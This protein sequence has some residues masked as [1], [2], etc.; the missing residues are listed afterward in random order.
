MHCDSDQVRRLLKTSN[1]KSLFVEQLGWDDH[2]ATIEAV[3]N[4]QA[5]K[6]AA[7]AQKRGVV[8]FVHE[9]AIPDDQTRRR[10]DRTVTKS[11][12]QHFIIFSDHGRAE[13]VWQWVRREP[14]KPLV[15]RQHRFHSSQSGESLIQKLKAITFSLKEEEDL[16]HVDV[17]GRVRAA[18]DT[19]RIT[20]RFYDR[21]KSEHEK[22]LDFIKGIP[23]DGLQHWYAAVMLNRLMFIY[24]VQKKEF[25]DNDINYLRTKLGQSKQ[26]G[27]DRFYTGFLC[28]LFFDGFAKKESER[29]TVT[30]ELLGKVPY[31]NGGLFLRHQVEELQGTSI[32][33]GDAAFER[34]FAFFEEFHWHLDERP[35]RNDREINPDVLGY[36]F[37]KYINQKQMGAYYTKE[38]ITGYIS[39]NTIIPFLFDAAR[40]KCKVAFEGDQS[41]WRLLQV[42]PDRYIYDAVKHGITIDLGEKPPCRIPEPPALPPEIACGLNDVSK[43]TEWN[44]SAAKDYAL[45][46][47]I[48]REVIARRKRY[49]DVRF[50]LASGDIQSINDLITYNLDIRQFAQDVIEQC[51][52]PDLLRAFWHAIQEVT[53]LDPTCGSGAFLFA[54]L[55]ILEPLYEACLNR[56]EV[57]LDELDRS[58]KKHR[59]EKFDDFR[60]AL[61]RVAKHASPRSFIYKSIIVNNLYGVDIMEEAVEICKLRLFLK[62]V[63][64]VDRVEQIEPL[65]D[66][67]FNIR[68]GNTLVGYATYDAVKQ[69]VQSKLDFENVMARIEEQAQDVDQLFGLFRRQQTELGGMV[70]AADKQNLRKRLKVLEEEL[71]RYLALEYQVN[72]SNKTAYLK[73]HD[74]H[75]PFHWLIEFYRTMKAGGFNVIIGNPP[76]VEY[77][78]KLQRQYRVSNYLTLACG[79][80]HAFVA[81]RSLTLVSRHGHVGLIVPLPSINTERMAA[82]QTIVKPRPHTAGRSTWISAYDERPSNLFTGVDQRLIIEIIGAQ[83][84][85][86]KLFTTGINRW[87]SKTRHLLF[88]TLSYAVQEEEVVQRTRTILKIKNTSIETHLLKALYSNDPIDRFRVSRSTKQLLAYRTAGG[89]YWKVTLDHPFDSKTLSG[90]VAYLEGISGKQAV[91]LISSS[92]FWWYYSCHFDMYNLKDYMI[93]GFRFSGFSKAEVEELDRLG[94]KLIKSLEENAVTQR[95]ES[96]TRGTVMQKL[97]VASKSKE[98]IDEIDRMLT[99]HYGFTDE[100]LD[101]I[102]NY[103][104]KYRMGRDA[105]GEEE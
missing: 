46:T 23:D 37:E 19:E 45:P 100:E 66:I 25:L 43:R 88:P 56:M 9:G 79:N 42:D 90:K 75:K 14:G 39:Q 21:F 28:P 40:Q 89:R 76:Y 31:L 84:Q 18:F 62:M 36:I 15:F 59:P 32:R 77:D 22:F 94:S 3:V 54:A 1:F 29:S 64:Q 55:N 105:E 57:F 49:E 13:Q 33:I 86:P 61:D 78:S 81:E 51:E 102:I 34:L 72:P 38:D 50:K 47:E 65:P 80:L 5:Y 70:T 71:N 16:H 101:F 2:S 48:W 6:L 30:N 85:N 99:K 11:V 83:S 26:R 10:I 96:R 4:G 93:F 69:A 91:A 35:N 63:A 104:I 97:Y 7:I 74:S 12:H 41:V 103:D 58:G 95:I 24:F 82:L 87:S 27:K 20:K 60:K 73:W 52:G 44:K 68:T 98:I 17:T 92:T 8:V 67:D 53:V